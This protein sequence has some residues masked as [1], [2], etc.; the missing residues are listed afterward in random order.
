MSLSKPVSKK[1]G[2]ISDEESF[3]ARYFSDDEYYHNMDIGLGDDWDPTKPLE[4]LVP[5]GYVSTFNS[6]SSSTPYNRTILDD[7]I[8]I[9]SDDDEEENKQQKKDKDSPNNTDNELNLVALE[10]FFNT[11]IDQE[12]EGEITCVQWMS[13]LKDFCPNIT[14]REM[15]KVFNYI[16]S[17]KEGYIDSVDFV[18][19]CTTKK[20]ENNDDIQQLQFAL[21]SD[22]INHPF[23]I[24]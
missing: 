24:R 1:K 22:I 20:F 9:E 8:E 14:E 7:D 5:I 3:D 12:L 19:F 13:A 18:T 2:T 11:I 17:E 15:Y 21:N 6:L 10:S 16:D 23:M 4:P